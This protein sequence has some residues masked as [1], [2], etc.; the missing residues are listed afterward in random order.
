LVELNPEDFLGLDKIFSFLHMSS[1]NSSLGFSIVLMSIITSTLF[2]SGTDETFARI[3]VP[4]KHIQFI[5]TAETSIP[6][7]DT[8]Y[9]FIIIV[10]IKWYDDLQELQLVAY[11]CRVDKIVFQRTAISGHNRGKAHIIDL[12]Y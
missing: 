12:K 4:C 11:P 3:R 10:S 6:M 9:Q 2:P 1:E 7:N 5:G 8:L